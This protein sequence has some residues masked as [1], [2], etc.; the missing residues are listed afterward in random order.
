MKICALFQHPSIGVL[1]AASM[2]GCDGLADVPEI[3]V[4]PETA[5]VAPGQSA[6]LH[7]QA[8][9]TPP[10]S[11]QWHRN[12]F[13]KPSATGTSLTISSVDEATAGVWSVKV[14]DGDGLVAWAFCRVANPGAV[15]QWSAGQFAQN[16]VNAAGAIPIALSEGD[17]TLAITSTG[18]LLW[19]DDGSEYCRWP[20]AVLEPSPADSQPA[21]LGPVAQIVAHGSRFAALQADGTVRAWTRSRLD[22]NPGPLGTWSHTPIPL[23][24]DAQRGKAV[25]I[26]NECVFV[27]RWDGTVAVVGPA[28]NELRSVPAGLTDVAAVAS[29]AEISHWPDPSEFRRHAV[30]LRTDG[31]V[32]AWGDNTYG[33]TDVPDGLTDVVQIAPDGNWTIALKQDGSLVQWGAQ[34]NPSG[35]QTGNLNAVNSLILG[36]SISSSPT[37]LPTGVFR[38]LRVRG[39][40]AYAVTST[41]SPVMWSPVSY[42]AI[43]VSSYPFN[44]LP[45]AIS[46]VIAT[47]ASRSF[48]TALCRA[49]QPLIVHPPKSKALFAGATAT[50]SVEATARP[51]PTY[52]WFKGGVV[53]PGATSAELRITDFAA[54]DADSYTVTVKNLHGEVTSLPAVLT[55]ANGPEITT[56][57]QNAALRPG[58][59]TTLSLTATGSGALTYRWLKDGRVMP[60]AISPSLVIPSGLPAD[61]GVYQAEVADANGVRRSCLVR[62][63]EGCSATGWHEGAAVSYLEAT[64]HSTGDVFL[65]L[66]EGEGWLGIGADGRLGWFYGTSRSMNYSGY[67]PNPMSFPSSSGSLHVVSAAARERMGLALDRDG[68]VRAWESQTM[69]SCVSPT[70]IGNTSMSCWPS[71]NARPLAVP[72]V[73]HGAISVSISADE[74]ALALHADG[75]VVAWDVRW[76]TLTSLPAAADADVVA[77]SSGKDHHLALKD[78]GSVI[79]WGDNSEGECAVPSGLVNVTGIAAL[80]NV[81]FA[82]L[83]DG[84]VIAW[85]DNSMGQTDVPAGLVG[86]ASIR[87]ARGTVLATKNDGTLAVW[88]TGAASTVP[89]SITTARAAAVMPV[90]P[91]PS[92]IIW[93]VGSNGGSVTS[94]GVALVPVEPPVVSV[95]ASTLRVF[96]GFSGNIANAYAQSFPRG[97]LSGVWLRNGTPLASTVTSSNSSTLSL[98]NVTA[99]DAGE[100]R[101]AF[102]N[103]WQTGHSNSVTLEVVQPRLFTGWQAANFTPTE[104]AAGL[105]A[106]GADPGGH[107]ITNLMRYALGLDPRHP[108]ASG[109]PRVTFTPASSAVSGGSALM[110]PSTATLSFEVPQ[111]TADLGIYLE[112]SADLT[113]WTRT[114]YWPQP[115]ALQNG[116]RQVHFN[117][118]GPSSAPTTGSLGGLIL[119]VGTGVVPSNQVFYRIAIEPKTPSLT[120]P[121]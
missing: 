21:D 85:G 99:A 60:G 37:P 120:P 6:E 36:S 34:S 63:G 24:L 76:G 62:T 58:M 57:P 80:E 9:G 41:G 53:I 89:S 10:L 26:D 109:L 12:G 45:P 65:A 11:Y 4:G 83:A 29:A 52:Q 78:D 40:S 33:Q 14:T 32:V 79:A 56:Q 46:E 75:R 54:E 94:Y 71:S 104:I 98:T 105:A 15:M 64:Q 88:G 103:G 48:M 113:T 20:Q 16:E 121:Y 72:A 19:T 73:A 49:A 116:R 59:G 74:E 86:V 90:D 93:I 3:I 91:P 50:L 100:Y 43:T 35:V 77:I 23:P 70:A 107:G 61:A 28:A 101:M 1:L 8:T 112:S 108:Q 5:V 44:P 115:G 38:S 18:G 25:F 55:L 13:P 92:G 51:L 110:T 81:S 27:V 87:G 42:G 82:I 22:A 111:D 2:L 84:S 31:S 17:P 67:S 39:S 96:P 30:A 119:G 118:S 66:S 117:A 69:A 68:N 114:G 7:V 102:D 95:W 97:P 47:S 106:P